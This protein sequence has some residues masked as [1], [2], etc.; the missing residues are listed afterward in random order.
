MLLAIESRSKATVH[1]SAASRDSGPF[2]C[3]ECSERVS[4]RHGTSNT[5]H[6]SHTPSGRCSFGSGE[7]EDHRRCKEAVFASLKLAPNVTDL[8]LERKIGTLRPDIFAHI[9][10][11]PV[12][13]EVQI[14]TLSPEVITR[15]TLAYRDAGIHVLWLL[16]WKSTLNR[17]DY[18]PRRFERWLHATY[19]GRVY[20][21][22]EGSTVIPY[23]FEGTDI[24][25][26]KYRWLDRWGKAHSAG[27]YRKPSKRF[28][29]AV[30]GMPLDITQ[31]FRAVHRQ[32]WSV[33][34]ISVP[35]A[36]LFLDTRKE[37]LPAEDEFSL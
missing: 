22:Y 29:R 1:A 14:S 21:W 13:I 8:V 17:W 3:P 30:R 35:E 5:A 10:N 27:G 20:F 26:E 25:V 37:F 23:R 28:K 36:L 11:V 2:L 15:R 9:D 33:P 12:G 18:S 4:L 19:F 34:Q 16:Q 6:F 24:F 7:T 31:D 32:A